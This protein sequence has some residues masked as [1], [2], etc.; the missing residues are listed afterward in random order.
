MRGAI[1]KIRCRSGCGATVE[2]T[3]KVLLALALYLEGWK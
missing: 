1:D 3:R 2:P